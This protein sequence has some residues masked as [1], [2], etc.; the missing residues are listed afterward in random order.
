MKRS[1]FYLSL[2]Y[3][4]GSCSSFKEV[5]AFAANSEE[6]IKSYQSIDYTFSENCNYKCSQRALENSNFQTLEKKCSC[7]EEQLAD[8]NIKYIL[9]VLEGYF[10]GLSNLSDSELTSYSFDAIQKPLTEGKYIKKA[11]IKPYTEIASMITTLFTDR[12]RAKKLQQAIKIA[13]SNVILLLEKASSIIEDNL[14]PT[15]LSRQSE[16]Q[17]IYHD[18]YSAS[19]TSSFEKFN[20]QKMYISEITT[21]AEKKETLEKYTAA[22]GKISKG[23]QSLNK[24]KHK[25]KEKEI[26]KIIGRYAND[27]N[28]IVE[29]IK[30]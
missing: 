1:I 15:L 14:L 4:L 9:K 18:L 24:N 21:I 12:Y 27:L 11:D 16:I 17:Q 20:I 6:S 13:N 8:K 2:L 5:K 26:R 3:V 7:E 19:V 30:K 28:V 29:Q 22:L 23:H 10:K 25:L